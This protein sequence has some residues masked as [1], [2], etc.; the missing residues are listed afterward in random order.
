MFTILDSTYGNLIAV[1]VQGHVAKE[2]YDKVN[3]LIDKAVKEY[4]KIKLFIQIDSLNGI[5]PKAFVED[6]KTYFRHFKDIEKMA[7]VGET[8]WQEFWVKLA[9]PFIS[10][11]V[12][13]FSHSELIA[14]QNWIRE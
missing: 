1:Q 5:E 3:P 8:K 6:V 4:G 9:G 10:G 2:D 14:A 11:K 13:Y 7:V 12:K